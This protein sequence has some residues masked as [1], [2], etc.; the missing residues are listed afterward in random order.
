MSDEAKQSAG[1]RTVDVL[2]EEEF[3]SVVTKVIRETKELQN[4]GYCMMSFALSVAESTVRLA[5][6]TKVAIVEEGKE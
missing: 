6:N 5:Y 3:L 4:L 2:S 1:V